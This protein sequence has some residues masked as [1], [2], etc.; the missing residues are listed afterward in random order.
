[1]E[2]NIPI[3]IIKYIISYFRG[4]KEI[5]GLKHNK[6]FELMKEKY[7]EIEIKL[8]S[9][10]KKLEEKERKIEQETE[11]E[12]G[13]IFVKQSDITKVSKFLY[14]TL[15]FT[16]DKNNIKTFYESEKRQFTLDL[17]DNFYKKYNFNLKDHIDLMIKKNIIYNKQICK[18]S[19]EKIVY[20]KSCI[21]NSMGIDKEIKEILDVDFIRLVIYKKRI[22]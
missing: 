15:L 11:I 1:M 19:Q 20:M 10:L 14:E 18:D 21:I 22:N 13:V 4:K 3:E 9:D 12:E 16:R 2:E 7:D 8:V 6:I 17:Y 5:D